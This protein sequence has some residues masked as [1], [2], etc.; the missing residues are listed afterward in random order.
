MSNNIVTSIDYTV[1]TQQQYRT[2][3]IL[4]IQSTQIAT[5]F[6][7]ET[8]N[9]EVFVYDLNNQ[10]VATDY[11]FINYQTYQDST[12]TIG[13][14]FVLNNIKIDPVA[15]LESYFFDSGEYII[16][17]NF[18][19][20][21]FSSSVNTPFFIKE[22]SPSRTELRLDTN[23]LTN[24][25]LVSASFE[26]SSSRFGRQFDDFYL[27]LGDNNVIIANNFL[28]DTTTEDYSVLVKLY[29]P[30]PERF[31]LKSQTWVVDKISDPS[32]FQV[33]FIFEPI[34][35][36]NEFQL[37]G[38]NLNLN[39][40]DQI[41]NSEAFQTYNTILSSSLTSSQQQY[42]SILQEKAININ[43]DFSDF[44]NFIHFSSAE[45]RLN[46]FFYK[47]QEIEN[48]TS[49]LNSLSTLTNNS[50]VSSSKG[51]IEANINNII[52]NFDEYEYYLYYDSSSYSWPKS[53]STKP[54]ILYPTTSSQ[55]LTWF[56]SAIPTSPYYGG[57]ILSAS[58]F[59]E[60]NQNYL[61]YSTPE[62]L[63][64][65]PSNESYMLFIDMIGQLFDNIWVYYKDVTNKYDADNRLDF[66]VSKDLI[67]EVIRDLG[68]K[69]YQNNF[70]NQDV[71]SAFLGINPQGGL[72][73]STGSELITNYV[74][75]SNE[76][77]P[78]DDIE[79]SIYKRI[80]HNIPYLLKTKG[81]VTGLQTIISLYGVPDTILRV[82]EFGGK[83]KNNTNDW[84]YWQHKFNYKYDTLT[85]GFVSS[86][87][88]LNTDWASED[89][90]PSTL[91]FRFKAPTSGSTGAVDYAVSNPLSA[92]WS[93]DTEAGIVLEYTG[94]GFVT[95]SYSGST[96][97]QYYQY[98]T[99]KFIPDNSTSASLYFPFFNGEWWSVMVTRTND[100]FVLQIA[101]NIYDGDDGSSIGYTGSAILTG[102]NTTNWITAIDSYFGSPTDTVTLAGSNY[103]RFSGSYQEIRYYNTGLSQSNFWDYAMNPDSIEGNSLNSAPSTLAF[104]A[105]LGGELETGS[106]SIH[107]KITGS[108]V[109]TSSFASNSD[110]YTGSGGFSNNKEYI[111]LDQPAVGIQNIVS[112]KIQIL[113]TILAPGNTSGNQTTVGVNMLS[114]YRSI[115]IQNNPYTGSYTN[116][117]NY[118]EVAF[119]PQNEINEDIMDSLGYFN[120]GD[121]IGDPRQRFNQDVSYPALDKLRNE[122]FEKYESNYD[123]NDY[124]NLI[125]YFDNSLFK[126]LQ[127][128]TPARTSLASGVVI[129][130][131]LLERNK[132]PLP[133]TTSSIND[134]SGSI[135]MGTIEGGA[136]GTVNKYNSLD[137]NP[138][139][140]ANGLSNNYGLT[141]SWSES[142]VTPYG[143]DNII[144]SSQDEFYNGEYSGSEFVVENGELNEANPFK[145]VPTTPTNYTLDLWSS[146]FGT[147]ESTFLSTVV[148]SAGT[149]SFWSQDA[150][151]PIPIGSP[152][153][154]V[155]WAKIHSTDLQGNNNSLSL[156]ALETLVTND[157][158]VRGPFII[159]SISPRNSG[160]YYVLEFA[161]GNA[162]YTFPGPPSGNVTRPNRQVVFSPY[163]TSESG[164]F[165]N[166]DYNAIINNAVAERLS[167]W[168][169]QVDYSTAQTVPV[170]FQQIISG[171]A[172][173]AA[174]QD[175]NYTSYQYSGIRY[176]GSKNTTD[177][178]NTA[179]ISQSLIVQSYQNDDIGATTLG[180]ASVDKFDSNILEFNWGGG[181]Y[182]EI[183]GGGALSLNQSLLVGAN[184]NA[185]GTFAATEPGFLEEVSLTFP[186]NSNPV[187]NQYTTNATT[188][189]GAKVSGYGFSVPPVSSYMIFKEQGTGFSGTIGV[190]RESILFTSASIVTTNSSGFY[191][192]GSGIS[193]IDMVAAI[194]SSLNA[195]DKWFVSLF[196]NLGSTVQGTL[197]PWNSGSNANYSIQNEDGYVYPLTSKGVFEVI[198][199]SSVTINIDPTF[200]FPSQKTV[201]GTAVDG[202]GMLLWKATQG[203]FILFNDATLS[204]LG[205]GGLVTST[206]SPVIQKDFTYI[207]QEYG[208]NPK[209][210]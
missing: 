106:I 104:R 170:N 9:I 119:S 71:F 39:F 30:L 59:D 126:M 105:S 6:N 64:N 120:I 118:T 160:E 142:I 51:I 34:V 163:I 32:S 84:D 13:S 95:A 208:T 88:S 5:E 16:N 7:P 136:G 85:S 17:Y 162:A 192:T 93:L 91:E 89:N 157:T 153:P 98:G 12:N 168:Y 28:L 199:A 37:Q 24:D 206:P 23:Y 133:E 72:F 19:R 99:L 78:L 97:D 21:F 114:P 172:Y 15:D 144:R 86:S 69:I 46:N 67:A 203:A 188:V 110:F 22:I 45:A 174:I 58:N 171:T 108:W 129:K 143:L 25:Q 61:Y 194:S 147:S 36:T 205:K 100:T 73:P 207:T 53:T 173:P 14:Q 79:K 29:E 184:R 154:Y 116:N 140:L 112:N 35:L 65:D 145:Q 2:D 161:P 74:T 164:P 1:L 44:N 87:W 156:E 139:Y 177:N 47:V 96:V 90:V 198:S 193:N 197:L 195:G 196:T 54:Y 101:N 107:P 189:D 102:I 68:V 60:D 57:Q 75:S 63:R 165:Q 49:D 3:D 77:I 141:Q 152:S 115:Q 109:A 180:Y 159:I 113:P 176:W 76:M 10:I 132:Y 185:I 8:D 210:Q 130:Q 81:T 200:K 169:Q 148:P 41:N 175:S 179:S 70:S 123:F 26:F 155:Q 209:N 138:Y 38:P 62:Y 11:N 83:D 33:E 92:L 66:G 190:P 50:Q 201:G 128:F 121:Y 131:N 124:I 158:R 166:S 191:T 4:L 167:E 43:I 183:I 117:V 182:P 127:D 40:K 94:S 135:L 42:L 55:V 52:E 82:S 146:G 187:F 137:T 103:T 20:E 125:K 186:I 31:G 122:Y 18:Y 151:A 48:Y 80:Y 27:N 149:A 178:F 202:V 181:T 150:L 204:G 134:F 111:F 56:G